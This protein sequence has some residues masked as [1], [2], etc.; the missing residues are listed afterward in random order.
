MNS[1]ETYFPRI[2][3][4]LSEPA[5][6]QEVERILRAKYSCVMI[7]SDKNKLREFPMPLLILIDTVKDA[8]DIRALHPV[9]GTRILLILKEDDS[10]VMSAAI[11]A[12]VDDFINQPIVDGDLIEKI[13]KYLEAIDQAT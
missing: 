11:E 1:A 3:L 5:V 10:E 8:F 2:A 6:H 12:G 7:I 9:G 4:F 13:E